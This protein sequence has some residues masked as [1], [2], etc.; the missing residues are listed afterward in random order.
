MLASTVS[1]VPA[2]E[3]EEHLGQSGVPD[4]PGSWSALLVQPPKAEVPA[5]ASP[6]VGDARALKC[7]HMAGPSTLLIFPNC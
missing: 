5:D 4:E 2:W 6:F 3:R 1:E 7:A